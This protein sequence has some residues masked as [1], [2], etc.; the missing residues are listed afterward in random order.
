MGKLFG[1]LYSILLNDRSSK[2]FSLGVVLGL[3]FSISIILSTL[4]IMDGFEFALKQSLKLASGDITISSSHGFFD[5][6]EELGPELKGYHFKEYTGIVKT[7]GFLVLD[8]SSMGV[9]VVGVDSTP[10]SSITGLDLS[11]KD[12][13]VI[14]GSELS[15]RA[16]LK[17]DD[18]LSIAFAQTNKEV[19]GLPEL[20]DFKVKKIVSHGIYQ[21]DLRIVYVNRKTLQNILE[22]DDRV[23]QVVAK[24]PSPFIYEEYPKEYTDQ[25]DLMAEKL[26]MNL[27]YTYNV[28]T[29]WREFDY[30]IKAV[31]AEK[32]MISLVLQI[33][34]IISI[35]NVVAFIIFLN[36][37]KV[38]EI[39]LFRAL[40]MGEKKIRRVWYLLCIFIWLSSCVVSILFVQFF[41]FCLQNLPIFKLPGNVYQLGE[42]KLEISFFSYLLVFF[43]ALVWMYF[44]SWFTMRRLSKRSLLQ[45]LRQEFS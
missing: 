28:R 24:V 12:D 16:V 38:Q 8:D 25:V 29:F 22:L 43:S 42:L 13:E 23:N 15:K 27:G 39:F 36:E 6:E 21:K 17:K 26:D 2:R 37:R 7:E 35:F 19:K 14:L 41:D 33:I 31:S 44:L 11:L 40:G 20:F 3:G 10:Y 18:Y 4:G 34:V 9:L 1:D 30:I 45:A 32:K 5:Y